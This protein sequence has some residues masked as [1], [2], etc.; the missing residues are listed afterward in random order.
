MSG[1]GFAVSHDRAIPDSVLD[2]LKAGLAQRGPDGYL[3]QRAH[4]AVLTHAAF[5]TTPESVEHAQP[6]SAS[7]GRLWITADARL[8]NRDDLLAAF[9]A[10]ASVRDS[11]AALILAAYEKWGDRCVDHLVGDFAFVVWDAAHRRVIAA[12]DPIG[13]RELFYA[14]DSSML[15]IASTIAALRPA[16]FS[17]VSEPFL[18]AFLN[19]DY[20]QFFGETA[21]KGVF[22]LA[23]GHLLTATTAAPVIRPYYS[24]G[25]LSERFAKDADYV[26]RFREL[27]SQAVRAQLRT[28]GPA[29]MLVSGGLDSSAMACV[30]DRERRAGRVTAQLRAYS[31]VFHE[32][33]SADEREY[34]DAVMERC[35]AIV[36]TRIAND[37]MRGLRPW[38]PPDDYGTDEPELSLNR[39][40]MTRLMRPASQD[41]CRVLLTGMHA[42][43]VLDGEPYHKPATLSEV[44]WRDLPREWPHY[45]RWARRSSARLLVD[46]F[47]R[48]LLRPLFRRPIRTT[49]LS[50]PG[51]KSA[52]SRASLTNLTDGRASAR[53]A[54][55]AVLGSQ[56]GLEFRFP[57]LDR[58][59]IEFM[60]GV[61]PHL[62]F[63]GGRIKH[64]LRE[65]CADV[66]PPLVANRV[67]L[68]HFGDVELRGLKDDAARL[69]PMLGQG[70]LVALG[71]RKSEQVDATLALCLAGPS[72]ETY[73]K[74]TRL[75]SVERWLQQIQTSKGRET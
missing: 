64:I 2:C 52:M 7:A 26:E 33:P 75:V 15:R 14:V 40:F 58:R 72:A 47:A 3:V 28:V 49:P 6:A 56:A 32:T 34:L 9:G 22:R 53:M 42:D 68:T 35:P 18:A 38:T 51:A 41:G 60:L 73:M 67:H 30:A 39:G 65:A 36:S 29:A 63:A 20:G 71:L 24:W 4:P 11:D 74:L 23:P 69:R 46:G 21:I 66:L 48:P 54:Q 8:D 17:S 13:V 59:L 19:S 50:G 57:F 70:L 25:N 55:A 5:H 44:R 31:A 27:F 10:R 37:D 16:S 62:R 12:R 1:I 43:Q 45:K 61:P